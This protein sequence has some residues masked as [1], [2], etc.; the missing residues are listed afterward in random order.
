MNEFMN[1]ATE[2]FKLNQE[3]MSDLSI[4]DVV[5]VV[6]GI[7]NVIEEL[8]FQLEYLKKVVEYISK[9]KTRC[10]TDKECPHCGS[11]LYCSDLPQY[12]YV[13]AECDENFYECEVKEN[14]ND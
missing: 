13:C 11:L 6:N 4:V 10:I 14:N 2:N 7:E 12:D 8:D 5:H 9:V 1:E 3:H